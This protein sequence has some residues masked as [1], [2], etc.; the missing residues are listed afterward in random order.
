M[1]QL[2]VFIVDDDPDAV[3][4]LE[5]L[6]RKHSDIKIC[7]SETDPEQS[8]YQIRSNKPDLILLDIEMPGIGGFDILNIIRETDYPPGVIFVTGYD[9]YAIKAIRESAFDYLLKPVDP[10][11]LRIA[12]EKFADS[13]VPQNYES[14]DLINLLTT[15]EREVF[16]LLRRGN[17][18]RQISEILSISKNTV[19]THRRRI[20]KKLDIKST[21]EIHL[22]FPADKK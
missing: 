21:T 12:L 1:R 15:R 22:N 10:K 11:E 5:I 19:D 9:K 3:A 18:S 16:E 8:V 2:R 6:L 20:L 7:G 17:T 14:E 13:T 4:R